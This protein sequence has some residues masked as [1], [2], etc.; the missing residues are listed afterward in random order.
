MTKNDVLDFPSG[1]DNVNAVETGGR[2]S[3]RN[4]TDLGWLAL[5]VEER[6]ECAVVV[7]VAQLRTRVPEL[8]RVG[9]IGNI[10]EHAN[11]FTVLDLVK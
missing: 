10:I 6:T 8:L 4:G 5:P 9:L 1:V 7:F 2:T 11:Y 3:V